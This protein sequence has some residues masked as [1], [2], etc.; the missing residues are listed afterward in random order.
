MQIN[1][2]R[3]S[4]KWIIIFLGIVLC[5]TLASILISPSLISENFIKQKISQIL[6]NKLESSCETGEVSFH[7]PNRINISSLTTQRQE[8]SRN[9]PIH[10]ENI[11]CK[12][13]LLPLL[14]KKFVVKKVYIEYINYENQFLIRDLITKKFSL[15]DDILFIHA[16]FLLNGGPT[17]IKGTIIPRKREP[18]IFDFLID[19]TDAR[20]NHDT[21][22]PRILPFFIIKEGEVGGTLSV[23]GFVKGKG[24]DK[25]TLME[26]LTADIQLVVKDGYIQGNKVISSI[27]EIAGIQNVYS[28]DV[29]ESV[30]QIRDGKIYTPKMEMSGPFMN[31]SASGVA[32]FEGALSYDAVIM[33]HKKHLRKDIE[34][35]VSLALKENTLP[36]E[37]RGTTENPKVSIK[38][39][40]N[41]LEHFIKDLVNDFLSTPGK[42]QKDNRGR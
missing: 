9:T 6:E 21:V 10:F 41:M 20:I 14:T 36:I 12:V 8:R 35:I 3:A 1:S 33:F 37:I 4:I 5:I 34:K 31:L 24:L 18:P 38:L 7:W 11:Q 27:L 40:K 13:G 39:Q 22:T 25:K 30:V 29:L 26:D 23:K 32:E 16:G 42:K 28:F 17:T 15:K 19:V 2:T